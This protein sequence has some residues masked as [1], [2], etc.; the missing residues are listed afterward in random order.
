[1]ASIRD[2]AERAGLSPATVSLA[3]RGLGQLNPETRARVHEA[4][5]ALSYQPHP[6]ISKALSL[7]RQ[8]VEQRYRETIAFVIEWET[9]TGPLHQKLIF[10]GAAE[11]AAAMGYK[12]EQYIVSGKPSD[13]RR[14]SNVLHARGIRGM[15]IIPRLGSPQPR[16]YFDWPKF[17]AVEIG[18]TIS[19]PRSLHHVDSADFDKVIEALH[20]LKKVGYRRIGMAVEPKQNNDS[21]G[22]FFAAYLL[23]QLRLPLSQRLPILSPV[24]PWNEMSFRQWVEANKPDVLFIHAQVGALILQWLKNMK[25]RVPQDISLFCANITD[26]VWSGLKRNYPRIGRSAVD[27]VAL[28]IAD[29]ELGISADPRSWEVAGSWVAGKTLSRPIDKY[30][31]SDGLISSALEKP[32]NFHAG[33]NH[34]QP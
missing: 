33:W 29:S 1:M 25:L 34:Y 10:N 20:L 32:R 5:K 12:L 19:Y 6:L 27:M 2:I 21:H 22:S 28:L 23:A 17:A 26:G 9:E 13:H 14:L 15:I 16:L 24:G 4:A 7:V 18:H 11:R 3:L 30:I 8:P 31:S